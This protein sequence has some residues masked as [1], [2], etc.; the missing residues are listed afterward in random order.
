[1]AD[2]RSWTLN[3]FRVTYIRCFDANFF[4]SPNRFYLLCCSLMCLKPAL[5]AAVLLKHPWMTACGLKCITLFPCIVSSSN[6]RRAPTPVALPLWNQPHNKGM[7]RRGGVGLLQHANYS[8][9]DGKHTTHR[10]DDP[11]CVHTDIYMVHVSVL[12]AR[13]TT[14]SLAA[15]ISSFICLPFVL[16]ITS[17]IINCFAH[18]LFAKSITNE[19][20][21][22]M[23][24]ITVLEY[25]LE[26]R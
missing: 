25:I 26:V 15:L 9:I 8:N 19:R 12:C 11:S 14:P 22:N 18:Y 6:L 4:P 13:H 23:I 20:E 17:S 2:I 24:L 5:F 7:E 10:D 3:I 21:W 1:V 16:S